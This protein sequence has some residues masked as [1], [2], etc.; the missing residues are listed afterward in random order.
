MVRSFLSLRQ[1]SH[2]ARELVGHISDVSGDFKMGV[3]SDFGVSWDFRRS[4]VGIQWLFNTHSTL[5]T[6]C[7][8][9]KKQASPRRTQTI[10]T[11]VERQAMEGSTMLSMAVDGKAIVNGPWLL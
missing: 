5:A 7:D 6:A 11:P 3:S 8:F 4:L 2:G 9:A 10:A 1:W